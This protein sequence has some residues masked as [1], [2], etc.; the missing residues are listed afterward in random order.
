MNPTAFSLLTSD[1]QHEFDEQLAQAA[2]DRLDPSD[3]LAEV[4]HLLLGIVD[5][6]QH[7]LRAPVQHCTDVGMAQETGTMP[8]LAEFFGAAL[9][10]VIECA[11]S[12]LVQ[13]ALGNDAAWEVA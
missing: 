6:D 12:R 5:D 10:P 1:R 4:Q 8:H 9:M 11:I 2:R 3:V 13:Q 7:P